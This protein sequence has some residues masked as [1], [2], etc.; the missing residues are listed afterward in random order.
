MCGKSCPP[1]EG[2]QRTVSP[3]PD[4]VRSGQHKAVDPAEMLA[5]LR[6]NLGGTRQVDVAIR[7]IRRRSMEYA[8]TPHLLRSAVDVTL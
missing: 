5:Q 1:R 2:S 4:K 7:N 6:C 8:V 3:S